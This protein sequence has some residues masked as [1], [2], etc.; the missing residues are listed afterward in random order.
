MYAFMGVLFDCTVYV[1]TFIWETCVSVL[2]TYIHMYMYV[3]QI[4]STHTFVCTYIHV[5]NHTHTGHG[6]RIAVGHKWRLVLV[7]LHETDHS[8]PPCTEGA[9][10]LRLSQSQ[11]MTELS[12][13]SM[14]RAHG[15]VTL[16]KLCLQHED[17]LKKC[18][19]QM[20]QELEFSSSEAVRN[21]IVLVLCDLV[22]RCVWGGLGVCGCV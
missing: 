10:Q 2:C 1:C 3:C 16:G 4:Y 22:V 11:S 8:H 6:V 17:V 18:L 9:R 13:P 20:V 12:L 19:L 15:Y 5:P 21:N 7:W 14:V